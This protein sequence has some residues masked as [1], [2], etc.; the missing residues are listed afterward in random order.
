MCPCPSVGL[1]K[2]LRGNAS[3]AGG[4]VGHAHYP[5]SAGAP[6]VRHDSGD[7]SGT[8]S[9]DCGEIL[10]GAGA[11][12]LGGTPSGRGDRDSRGGVVDSHTSTL[13]ASGAIARA[14]SAEASSA[15]PQPNGGGGVVHGVSGPQAIPRHRRAKNPARMHP[16]PSGSLEENSLPSL[17]HVLTGHS[18]HRGTGSFTSGGGSARSTP[19]HNGRG[20]QARPPQWGVSKG[21]EPGSSAGAGVGGGGVAHKTRFRDGANPFVLHESALQHHA[22]DVY[23][24]AR[25]AHAFPLA[26]RRTNAVHVFGQPWKSLAVPAMLPLT[27]DVDPSESLLEKTHDFNG[28][29]ILFL[30]QRE[31]GDDD[32]S[33]QRMVLCVH[34][35]VPLS[36]AAVGGMQFIEI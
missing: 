8:E 33:F 20:G 27:S 17:G 15:P 34:A 16:L 11:V 22:A 12:S 21:W 1:G 28:Y 30:N 6:R 32:H 10:P 23:I 36:S 7:N 5:L 18:H 35:G 2:H 3:G 13:V 19:W 31:D 4:S 9:S 24:K 29:S 26:L 14:S 25:W